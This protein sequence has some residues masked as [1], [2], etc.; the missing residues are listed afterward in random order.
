MDLKYLRDIAVYIVTALISVLIIAYIIIQLVGGFGTGVDTVAAVYVTE[1]SLNSLDAY[2]IR[3]E[4][5]LYAKTAGSVSY[6]YADGEKVSASSVVAKV[7][8]GGDVRDDII[9]LDRRIK[10]LESSD[11]DGDI[12]VADAT[13][14]DER[15]AELYITIED[16]VAAGDF[17]Y[18]V[19]KRDE[20]LTLLN[21]RRIIVKAVTD[22]KE[23]IASLQAKKELLTSSLVGVPEEIVTPYAGYF[24]DTVDGYESA[25]SA[26]DIDTMT[27]TDYNTLTNSTAADIGALTGSGYAIGKIATDYAWY[28]ACRTTYEEL[29]NYVLN[30]AYTI[31]YPYSGD[32]EISATLYRTITEPN[33]DRVILIFKNGIIDSSFNFLRRQTVEI[34]HSSY[35][36]YRI[37]IS[38]ARVVD[39]VKGVYIL[40]GSVVAFREIVPLFENNG[41]LIVE[42]KDPSDPDQS[43]RLGLYD[44]VI[45]EGGDF[46]DGQIIE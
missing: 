3:H 6:N 37:P 2:I 24:Y 30:K 32:R 44:I 22:Y 1:R 31:I 12:A 21:K 25:F 42:A 20:L 7:F 9:A 38:A 43:N 34:V 46:Y 29:H 35:S 23:L 10:L 11:I 15:I 18:A 33:S 45:T 19:R 16:K 41:Y 14:I 8:G 13:T 39:G 27:M 40:N 28:T 26:I 17:D 5:V 4:T 36:G